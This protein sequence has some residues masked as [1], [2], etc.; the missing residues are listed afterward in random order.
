MGGMSSIWSR[1]Q[2]SYEVRFMPGIL[3]HFAA[4]VLWPRHLEHL[5][6]RISLCQG[7][8]TAPGECCRGCI[9]LKSLR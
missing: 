8:I 2:M 9:Y 5:D 7:I 3:W 6:L 4:D 1:E